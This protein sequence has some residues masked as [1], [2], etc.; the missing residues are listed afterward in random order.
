MKNS[1]KLILMLALPVL[2]VSLACSAGDAIGNQVSD[3]VGSAV[4]GAINEALQQA[5]AEYGFDLPIDGVSNVTFEDGSLNMQVQGDFDTLV[6]TLRVSAESQGLSEE[7]LYT[8]ITDST[9]SMVFSGH[10]SGQNIV[11]QM[12]D[13]GGGSVNVNVRFETP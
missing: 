5:M 2:V 10:E 13:L 1:T 9:A 11:L 3:A 4:E 8:S 7:D 12:V 6:Q